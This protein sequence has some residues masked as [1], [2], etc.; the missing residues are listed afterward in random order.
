MSRIKGEDPVGEL[1]ETLAHAKPQFKVVVM[2]DFYLDYILTYPGKL[3]DLT[4]SFL[5]VAQRGGGNLLGW[6]HTVGRGGNASNVV[7]QLSRLGCEVIPIIETDQLGRKVLDHF[8]KDVDLSHVKTTG[9]L[10]RTLSV[11]TEHAGRR[12][13]IMISDPGSMS[14]FGPEKLTE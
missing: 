12:V 11:E 2:P 14:E 9:S 6:G 3:E 7:A 5:E 4:A 13:N 8:L 1:K 10:S